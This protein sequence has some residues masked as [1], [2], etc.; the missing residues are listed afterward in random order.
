L[1]EFPTDKHVTACSC[2]GLV[3]FHYE[4][5]RTPD[6]PPAIGKFR[7]L[8]RYAQFLPLMNPEK[9]IHCKG[10]LE[11]PSPLYRSVGLGKILGM[12]NLWIKDE[13]KNFSNTLKARVAIVTLSRFREIG[14]SEFVIASTGNTAAALS[15]AMKFLDTPMKI[16]AFLPIGNVVDFDFDSNMVS[17]NAGASSYQSTI[18]MAR[19]FALKTGRIWEGGFGNPCRVEGEKTIA[20]E[21][22]EKGLNPDWYVQGVSSGT[23]VYGFNKGCDELNKF[24]G[25]KM[26]PAYLCVQ[27]EGCAPMVRAYRAGRDKLAPEDVVEF[28]DTFATTIANGAPYSCYKHIYKIV[29][30]SGGAFLDVSETAIAR[31]VH[32]LLREENICPDPAAAVALA[33]IERALSNGI[34]D[35]DETVLLN[36]S[37]AV[38]EGKS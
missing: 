31:A 17:I 4:Y 12:K 15:Y 2:D 34:I 21:I 14:I 8:A 7:G 37:G 3:G 26:N 1:Q 22:A 16:H 6:W 30:N 11:T 5:E 18:E 10:F 38:R 29:K 13:T 25:V 9:A 28:P 27:A 35:R 24:V 19:L 20:F 36:L 23:C 33:G 32:L